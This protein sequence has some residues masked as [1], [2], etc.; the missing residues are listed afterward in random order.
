MGRMRK[1]SAQKLFA[2]ENTVSFAVFATL[3]LAQIFAILLYLF[4]RSEWFWFLAIKFN[5]LTDPAINAFGFLKSPSVVMAW[6]VFALLCAL[7]VLAQRYRYWL[8]SSILG[9]FALG[10]CII[11]ASD[12]LQQLFIRQRSANLS[13][14]IDPEFL[15]WSTGSVVAATAVLVVLCIMNHVLYLWHAA[16]RR[17]HDR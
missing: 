5:R 10:L 4:P 17:R 13:S 11:S 12:T 6:I 8:T 16:E 2:V 15:N 14:V 7:P 1:I 3:A 9:H